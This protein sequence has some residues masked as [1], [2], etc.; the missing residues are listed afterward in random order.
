[1][2]LKELIELLQEMA[3]KHGDNLP[4]EVC[5]CDEWHSVYNI[6]RQMDVIAITTE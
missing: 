4:V 6:E 5:M 1:M 3:E 2:K